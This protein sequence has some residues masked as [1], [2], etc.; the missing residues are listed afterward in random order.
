MDMRFWWLR[1]HAFQ[2]QFCYYWDSGSKNWANYHTKHHPNTYHEAH[3]NIHAGIWDP[4]GIYAFHQ[5]H[6]ATGPQVSLFRFSLF[7]FL[8][9]QISSHHTLVEAVEPFKLHPIPM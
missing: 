3:Q 8:S 1:C 7:I 9:Y 5:A 6:L 2:D 4:A